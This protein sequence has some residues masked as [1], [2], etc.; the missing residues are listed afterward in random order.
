M[1]YAAFL[2]VHAGSILRIIK[3]DTLTKKGILIIA[4][5]IKCY[6]G[7]F[8]KASHMHKLEF[9]VINLLNDMH[10]RIFLILHTLFVTWNLS[11]YS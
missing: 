5:L 11:R 10:I 9:N 2:V 1:H 4:M 6:A 7:F 3:L 8:P